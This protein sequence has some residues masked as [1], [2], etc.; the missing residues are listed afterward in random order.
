MV[1]ESTRC[2]VDILNQILYY[3]TVDVG[4]KFGLHP[5]NPLCKIVILKIVHQ[6]IIKKYKPLR[7][8][9]LSIAPVPIR[10]PM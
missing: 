8:H 7:N 2:T 3:K 4:K 1:P 5:L 9:T 10:Y 6:I